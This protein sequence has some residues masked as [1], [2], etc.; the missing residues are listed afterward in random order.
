MSNLD[1]PVAFITYIRI[2]IS[3]THVWIVVKSI[4]SLALIQELL[5]IL[6]HNLIFCDITVITDN[7][8]DMFFFE[9]NI[10][11]IQNI[12]KR[13]RKEKKK[14]I[15]RTRWLLLLKSLFL[16]HRCFIMHRHD[17]QLLRH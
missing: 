15:L 4:F 11:C 3:L 17:E 1:E 7:F 14:K 13:N 16:S 10:I 2:Q 6:N 5:K 9:I 12:L 8:I